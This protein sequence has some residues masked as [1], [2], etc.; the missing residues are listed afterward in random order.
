ML[1]LKTIL[2][3]TD[4][5]EDSRF[6][7]EIA[8]SLARDHGTRLV[9]LHV[10]PSSILIG[11]DKNVPAYKEAH[12]DEDLQAHKREMS[13]Q[14]GS[15]QR[16]IPRSTKAE[17]LLKEGEVAA[18]IISAARDV[19]AD[20]IVMGTHGRSQAYQMLMGSVA[21]AVTGKAACPVLT[22]RKTLSPS[23]RADT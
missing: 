1:K 19:S 13:E 20:L 4:F 15:L 21:S 5:S 11:R 7:L 6:A 2:H 3:P 22:V 8:T 16:T 23:T 10:V 14:L 9:L 17:V 18:A 12:T